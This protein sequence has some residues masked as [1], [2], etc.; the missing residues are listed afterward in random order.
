[1][2][3]VILF[4]GIAAVN[5]SPVARVVG[6]GDAPDGKYPY[7]VSLNVLNSHICG[8]S[9]IDKRFILTA[10][11]CVVKIP[12]V[13]MTIIV[14]TN[15]LSKGGAIYKVDKFIIHDFDPSMIL[16]DIALIRTDRDIEFN[17]KVQP[18]KISDHNFHL[19]GDPAVLTGW[20]YTHASGVNAPDR[21]QEINL[22]IYEH[23]ECEKHWWNLPESQICTLTESGEG[24]C[25]GDSGGPLVADGVQ[26][27]IVSYG[28]PCAQGLP[29]V[30]TRVYH[31]ADWIND[32]IN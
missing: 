29:D 11:H 26:I 25:M 24:A 12:E 15:S 28:E 8:G 14:G 5:G 9:I 22:K 7:Q 19:H 20:G 18:I 1:M 17:D 13:F 32:I 6:G 30:Y 31:Y 10:A 2:W 16:N 4:V 27:G 3:F 21:L 23:E